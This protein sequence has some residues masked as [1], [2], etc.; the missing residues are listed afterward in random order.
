MNIMGL[1]KLSLLDYPGK[2]CCT[3]FTAGCNM[4]CPFCHNASLV[5]PEKITGDRISQDEV[6][7]F[8]V[9]RKKVLDGVCISGG[10]PLLQKDIADFLEKIKELGYQIKLDTNGTF[11]QKLRQLV[12]EGLVDYV[13]MDIKNSP[14]RYSSTAGLDALDI[15]DVEESI[16]YLLKGTVDYEFRTTVVK[17]LHKEEDFIV[18]G[19]WLK[20]AKRYYLQSFVDSGDLIGK[21]MTGY[22]KETMEHFRQLLLKNISIVE[23]RGI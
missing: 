11:P 15:A 23:L 2:M 7:A 4:R 8:L 10:E 18:I 20:G 6:M 5:L 22:D 13:A 12:D 17:P 9:K 1:Q 3:V 19:T 21:N 16:R 14:E